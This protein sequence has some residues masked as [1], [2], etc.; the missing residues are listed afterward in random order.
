MV[1]RC[2]VWAR[3]K[4]SEKIIK[5]ADTP[6]S[7]QEDIVKTFEKVIDGGLSDP[8]EELPSTPSVPIPMSLASSLRP[9]TEGLPVP[10]PLSPSEAPR[11]STPVQLKSPD[12]VE[13]LRLQRRPRQR[14]PVACIL[15]PEKAQRVPEK[16]PRDRRRDEIPGRKIPE[17]LY[18]IAPLPDDNVEENS[19]EGMARGGGDAAAATGG[20]KNTFLELLERCGKLEVEKKVSERI[21]KVIIKLRVTFCSHSF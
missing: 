3:S 14:Q 21:S 4:T 8:L 13:F 15:F 10:R 5:V 17:E 20:S 18:V 1:F 16:G 7:S 6:P 11:V 12:F 19:G 9:L 2:V